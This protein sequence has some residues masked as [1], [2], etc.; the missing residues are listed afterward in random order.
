MS[1]ESGQ[2]AKS[3][4]RVIGNDLA[5]ET[6]EKPVPPVTHADLVSIVIP[7]HGQLEYT[8]LCI[9]SVLRHS[10]KPY[11]LIFMD[12]G[13][14]DGTTEYLCGVAAA[15]PVRVEIARTAQPSGSAPSWTEGMLRP[16][17]DFIALL[18]NDTIVTERWL[19]HLVTLIKSNPALGMVGPMSNYAPP[20]QLV[21]LVPYRVVIKKGAPPA[22]P[23]QAVA[24]IE[25]FARDWREQHRNQWC[26]AERLGGGCVLLRRDV[27]KA[28]GLTLTR[29]PL[30]FFDTDALSSRIIQA[31]CRLACCKDLF[32]HHFGTRTLATTRPAGMQPT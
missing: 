32:V 5:G 26:D 8:R 9:P 19:E 27:V 13:S 25:R 18:S 6:G 23:H 15:A 1:P 20:P 22:D 21:D 16:R 14:F 2:D 28:I 31:N 7:C 4:S 12:G 17:G 3:D 29:S 30:G 10:R 11:E 24:E